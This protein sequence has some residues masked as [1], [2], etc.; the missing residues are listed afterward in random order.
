MELSLPHP[1][2]VKELSWNSP[3]IHCHGIVMEL[4]W[5]SHGIVMELSWNSHGIVMEW[6]GIVME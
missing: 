5:N 6:H 3:E 2:I 4:S 1:G